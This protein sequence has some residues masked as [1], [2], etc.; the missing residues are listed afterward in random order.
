MPAHAA[1]VIRCLAMPR[2]PARAFRPR[3]VAAGAALALFAALGAPADDHALAAPAPPSPAPAPS[4]VPAGAPSSSPAAPAPSAVPAAPAP[5]AVPAAPGRRPRKVIV[6][7]PPP[8]PDPVAVEA[9]SE[10]NLEVNGP[11]SGLAFGVFAMGWQQVGTVDDSGRGGGIGLRLGHSASPSTVVWV[12]LVAGA[13]PGESVAKCGMTSTDEFCLSHIESNATLAIS[14]QRYVGPNTWLRGGGGLATYTQVN[15]QLPDRNETREARAG[16][17][18][19]A[20]L[21]V[22]IVRRHQTRLSLESMVAVQRF[23]EGWI[24]DLGVGFGVTMY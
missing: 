8:I 4:A 2:G 19:L 7:P 3:P 18:V 11:R 15:V 1:S 20:G 12:E 9:A 24:F 17:G 21:G 23:A 5:S 16:L 14:G 10:A 22:D 13:F 6:E